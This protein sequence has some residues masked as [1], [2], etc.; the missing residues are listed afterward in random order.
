MHEIPQMVCCRGWY[1]NPDLPSSFR[2]RLRGGRIEGGLSNGW[3]TFKF[4]AE[5]TAEARGQSA[6][7]VVALNDWLRK[8]S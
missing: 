2:F 3:Y 7:L 8:Q 4:E 5:S 6:A 1:F